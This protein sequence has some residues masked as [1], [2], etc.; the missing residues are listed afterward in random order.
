MGNLLKEIT[1]KKQGFAAKVLGVAV[2]EKVKAVQN[3]N[4]ANAINLPA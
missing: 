2:E 3:A 1:A 4:K